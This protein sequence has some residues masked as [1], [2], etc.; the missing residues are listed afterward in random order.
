MPAARVVTIPEAGHTS[1]LT[2]P[3]QERDAAVL[4]FL[5]LPL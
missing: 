3:S 1:L 4:E 2:I 5:G